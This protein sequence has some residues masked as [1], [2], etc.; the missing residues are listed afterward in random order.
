MKWPGISKPLGIKVVSPEAKA[1]SMVNSNFDGRITPPIPFAIKKQFYKTI[2]R[3]QN[4]TDGM[5]IDILNREHF[6]D[7]TTEGQ[8]KAEVKMMEEWADT[9]K[10]DALLESMIRNWVVCGPHILAK[11][12]WMPIQL[13]SLVALKR[14]SFGNVTEFIQSINGKEEKLQAD[15][16]IFTGYTWMDR[17]AWPLALFESLMSEHEDIDGKVGKPMLSLYRQAMQDIMKIHHKFSSPRTVWLFPGA[18]K[19]QIDNDIS[20]LVETMKPGERL[21]LNADKAEIVTE[22]VDAK[23]RFSESVDKISNEVDAGLQTSKNRVITDP[24]AMADAREAGSQDD[25]RVLGIMKKVK[26]VIDQLI[27]PHVTGLPVG[28][29]EWKW[30]AKDQFD[31]QYPEPLRAALEDGLLTPEIVLDILTKQFRWKIP[32]GFKPPEVKPQQKGDGQNLTE[33][34]KVLNTLILKDLHKEQK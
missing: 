2:G 10:I 26:N 31:L 34:L 17:E 22:T 21:V 23:A 14:D 29:V 11:S 6:F 20:P 4:A 7:D 30:G 5:V 19:E 27:I 8:Y 1:K 18:D 12:D 28:K 9:W 32:D 33:S 16:F 3:V 15:Q 25:D 13:E 24:S